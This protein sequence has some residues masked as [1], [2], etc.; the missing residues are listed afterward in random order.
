MD[1]EWLP[2]LTLYPSAFLSICLP[3]VFSQRHLKSQAIGLK[4]ILSRPHQ[5]LQ[6]LFK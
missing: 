3:W 2:L 5:L 6:E 1:R 4:V